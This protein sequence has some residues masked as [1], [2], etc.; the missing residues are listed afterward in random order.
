MTSYEKL[1]SYAT[2]AIGHF[3]PVDKATCTE[4]VKYA[5]TL[6]SDHEIQMH[7]LNLLGEDQVL[8]FVTKFIQLKHEAEAENV[9]KQTKNKPSVTL[10]SPSTSTSSTTNRKSTAAWQKPRPQSLSN[11]SRLIRSTLAVATSELLD[12]KLNLNLN[13]NLNLTSPAP[14]K[15]KRSKM[16]SVAN[17]KDIEAALNELEVSADPSTQSQVRRTC[18]CM[19]TRH[20]LF[21]VAPNCLN[22]GKIICVKE[23]IQPCSYCGKEL[24]SFKDKFE[25]IDI[26]RHE[27]DTIKGIEKPPS[28][29]ATPE[30]NSKPKHSNK[31]VISMEPGKNNLWDAQDKALKKA[32]QARKRENALV[33]QQEKEQQ[34]L[35]QQQEEMKY[36]EKH[37]AINP[38][39]QMAQERLETLLNFQDTGAERTKII[40]NAADYDLPG[41]ASSS[42]WLSPI[43]RALQL[44]K[45]QKQLRKYENSEKE[46]T[47]RGKRVMDMVIRDGKAIWVEREGGGGTHSDDERESKEDEQITVLEDSVKHSKNLKENEMILLTWNYE[48]E[49]KK[50]EKPQYVGSKDNYSVDTNAVRVSSKVR[51]RDD[52]FDTN[53]LVVMI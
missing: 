29:L 25:I 46:R 19:G 22:C 7:F 49:L 43:E 8:P 39:L 20:P 44:K 23:G 18:N 42:M 32:D 40:D 35:L 27:R 9:K 50:W 47:G 45:Q 5:L 26:L 12:L 41:S 38:E 2:N 17:L 37:Q 16:R 51:T 48:K 36:F 13:L 24:L 33:E 10:N 14:T 11:G 6:G 15:S 4:M 34:Q 31:I 30:L 1:F 3:L 21:D 53:E 28:R 52:I